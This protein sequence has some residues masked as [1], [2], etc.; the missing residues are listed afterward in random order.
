MSLAWMSRV[1]RAPEP[2]GT[3]RLMLLSLA[4]NA[5]DEGVC[6]PAVATLQRKC[7]LKTRRAAEKVL[8]RLEAWSGR[9]PAGCVVLRV[10]HR[11]GRVSVYHLAAS[12]AG[13]APERPDGT[14]PRRT[15]ARAAGARPER[16]DGT[17]SNAR[18]DEPTG[19]P[20]KNPQ[21]QTA[22]P[23]AR[24]TAPPGA[25]RLGDPVRLADAVQDVVVG[26]SENA[27]L[28]GQLAARGVAE[29]VAADLVA[30]SDAAH[31]RDVL[32]AGQAQAAGPGWY[33]RAIRERWDVTGRRR[34]RLRYAHAE[35]LAALKAKGISLSPHHPFDRYFAVHRKDGAVWFEMTEHGRRHLA[36]F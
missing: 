17:P 1:F 16:R 28:C 33:V 35:A 15:A 25:V 21:Q 4:D 26:W 18:T 12:P 11:E 34:A 22:P 24:A 10:E 9:A 19:T 6:W 13:D 23:Q 32:A 3:D 20:R 31:V 5:N 14:P 7:G 27:D 36:R 8:R 2:H 30:A 29:P